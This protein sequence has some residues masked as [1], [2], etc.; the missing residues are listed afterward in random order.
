M[1]EFGWGCEGACG[2]LRICFEFVF[3]NTFSFVYF[4]KTKNKKNAL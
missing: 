3:Q 1:E 2:C 4:L